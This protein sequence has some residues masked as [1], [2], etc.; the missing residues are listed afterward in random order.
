[1][2]TYVALLRGINVSA[3]TQMPMADLSQLMAELGYTDIATYLRSGNVIFK[4]E[5]GT[6][7]EHEK[8]IQEAIAKRFGFESRI[9][10]K[11]KDQLLAAREKNPF[12]HEKIEADRTLFVSF[13]F[14]PLSKEGQKILAAMS[15]PEELIA[16]FEWEV[17]TL[18]V[19]AHFPQSA[20]GKNL[21]AKRAKADST[22]RNWNTLNK[23]I[24][25]M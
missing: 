20:M 17:Y 5:S 2:T 1:M 13:L 23:L 18:L 15:N 4:A 14:E 22:S 9:M 10:V 25:R 6:V 16:P 24:D 11:T 21:L 3:S 19:R 7:E 12:K 8:R